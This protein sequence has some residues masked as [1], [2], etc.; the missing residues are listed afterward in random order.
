[1]KEGV[2]GKLRMN[3]NVEIK[4]H[5]KDMINFDLGW[6]LS[7]VKVLT[8]ESVTPY[9]WVQCLWH[10]REGNTYTL[11]FLSFFRRMPLVT[12][13]AI[14]S[15]IN[16][17]SSLW[18][19]A[20]LSI[21]SNPNQSLSWCVEEGSITWT[22]VRVGVT[23]RS[24]VR[25]PL[26]APL[27]WVL[28]FSTRSLFRLCAGESISIISSSSP[29]TLAKAIGISSPAAELP[30]PRCIGLGRAIEGGISV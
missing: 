21:T 30:L 15:S 27:V 5:V 9:I 26:A 7:K 2:F 14:V 17:S 11:Q 1:M 8:R 13:S 22:G 25:L 19:V 10:S 12:L 24:R 28:A 29:N 18:S 3:G 23:V 20:S 4:R 6:E 16:N